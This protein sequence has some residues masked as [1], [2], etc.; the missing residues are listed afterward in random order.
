[1]PFFYLVLFGLFYC[2]VPAAAQE[3]N[4][5]ILEI[6]SMYAEVNKLNSASAAKSCKNARKTEYSGFSPESEQMPFEQTAKRCKLANGYEYIEGKF[7]GY[8]WSEDYFFYLRNGS[9]FFVF[10]QSSA[11]A[12]SDETRVYYD[13]SGRIIRLLEKT[14]DC[15]GEREPFR[16]REQTN[17]DAKKQMLLRVNDSYEKALNMLK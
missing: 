8:E 15:I 5:R 3:K 14:N 13:T 10:V 4:P 9:V 2:F 12:C 1:M 11:E 17:E 7:R 16:S 6:K